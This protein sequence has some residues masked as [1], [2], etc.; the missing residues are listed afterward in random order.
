MVTV[1]EAREAIYQRFVD[2]YSATQFVFEG[3]QFPDT[4]NE[5]VRLSVRHNARVQSTMG[6][7][8]NRRFR[9]SGLIV[10]QIYTQPNQGLRRGDGLGQSILGIYEG[11]GFSGIDCTTG[12]VRES[13]PEDEYTVHIASIA[14]D[15]DEI[16]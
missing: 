11:V 13:I 10:V 16:K 15:Y 4:P 3:E 6:G 1:V 7:T 2:N 14:F 5:W 8:G 9:A 12:L